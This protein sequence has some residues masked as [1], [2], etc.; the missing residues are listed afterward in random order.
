MTEPYADRTC[1]HGYMTLDEDEIY[2]RMKRAHC[3]GYQV[4][5]HAVGDRGI[6]NCVRLF[7]RLLEEHPR[8][9]HRHRIEHASIAD[10]DVLE[11]STS[12]DAVALRQELAHERRVIKIFSFN[13]HPFPVHIHLHLGRGAIGIGARYNT[14]FTGSRDDDLIPLNDIVDER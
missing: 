12:A 6:E 13:N 2:G 10:P 5:I 3:A 9:D 1:S 4:C 11:R 14:A 8:E 7:E